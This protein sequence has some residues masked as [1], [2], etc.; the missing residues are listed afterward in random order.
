MDEVVVALQDDDLDRGNDE[1]FAEAHR[2]SSGDSSDC[3]LCAAQRARGETSA[4]RLC[5]RFFA[6]MPRCEARLAMC[7]RWAVGGAC[8]PALALCAHLSQC[9]HTHVGGNIYLSTTRRGFAWGS[10]YGVLD[11]LAMAMAIDRNLCVIIRYV[12]RV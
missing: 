7:G 9:H 12:P 8:S 6:R 3:I 10:Y 1:R 11:Q 5:C 4:S 2:S